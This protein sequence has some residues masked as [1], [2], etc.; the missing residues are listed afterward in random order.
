LQDAQNYEDRETLLITPIFSY[1]S[2]A[3]TKE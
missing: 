2:F 3:H 1:K